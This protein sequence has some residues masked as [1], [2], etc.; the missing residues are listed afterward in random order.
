MYPS[1]K[2]LS[3]SVSNTCLVLELIAFS[4]CE[5]FEKVKGSCDIYAMTVKALFAVIAF[6]PRHSNILCSVTG[7]PC[8]LGQVVWSQ[9][10][11][12]LS[13][14]LCRSYGR[15]GRDGNVPVTLFVF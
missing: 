15:S 7:F 6:F 9:I 2:A 10:F 11:K 13:A 5:H 3:G 4:D 14:C 12:G 8:G 1:Y